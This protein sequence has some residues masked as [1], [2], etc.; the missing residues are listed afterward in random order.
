MKINL[1]ELFS[2]FTLTVLL[3]SVIVG[4]VWNI[5]SI[6]FTRFVVCFDDNGS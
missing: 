5:F 1:K 3:S 4:Y 2:N 6:V